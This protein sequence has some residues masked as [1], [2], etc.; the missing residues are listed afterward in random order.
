M[1]VGV[2][3]GVGEPE[4]ELGTAQ[5][6]LAIVLDEGVD[7]GEHEV[8][9]QVVL[10]GPTLHGGADPAVLDPARPPA[11]KGPTSA[12]GLD[13][14]ALPAPGAS[15]TRS[16]QTRSQGP[17]GGHCVWPHRPPLLLEQAWDFS[18]GWIPEHSTYF[19]HSLLPT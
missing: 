16:G 2:G 6:R 19:L 12:P 4:L 10:H 9:S 8:V 13:Q 7:A 18:T 14:Q 1:W 11:G 17:E 15:E 3:H 5:V